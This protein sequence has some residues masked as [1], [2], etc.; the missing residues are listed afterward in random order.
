[1]KSR[2]LLKTLPARLEPVPQ[3]GVPMAREQ[4]LLDPIP[5]A[6]PELSLPEEHMFRRCRLGT[7]G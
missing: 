2:M 1:M 7:R 5:A 3:A 6:K 4:E